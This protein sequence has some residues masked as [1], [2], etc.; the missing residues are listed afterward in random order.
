[1]GKVAWNDGGVF[2]RPKETDDWRG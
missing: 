1:M 2:E